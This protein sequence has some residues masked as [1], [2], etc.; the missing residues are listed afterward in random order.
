MVYDADLVENTDVMHKEN[1]MDP[2][3]LA[4]RI[5]KIFLTQGGREV[6]EEVLLA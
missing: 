2:E 5:K 3:K 1:P 4:A 6:A